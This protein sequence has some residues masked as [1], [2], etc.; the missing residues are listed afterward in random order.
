M[1]FWLSIA[2]APRVEPWDAPKPPD[3][4]EMAE[5]F[6]DP[7][8]N[9]D[10]EKMADLTEWLLGDGGIA[11]VGTVVVF[12]TVFPSIFSELEAGV[13]D[14]ESEER[15]GNF[16][17]DSYLD[18]DGW[19]R[20]TLPCGEA[21]IDQANMVVNT[22]FSK[23]GL[24]PRLWGA[25][26]NCKWSDAELNLDAEMGFF[27]PFAS[28]MIDQSVWEGEEGKWFYFDGELDILDYE[29][30]DAFQLMWDADDHMKILW[31]D[32]N[33]RFVIRAPV[34]EPETLELNI[35][36]LAELSSLTIEI[37]TGDGDWDCVVADGNCSGPSGQVIDW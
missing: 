15:A 6:S 27:V 18:G 17:E 30:N 9:L 7:K 23:E 31:E 4:F 5:K 1:L 36:D 25:S 2:C 29:V 16:E 34:I 33:S 8:G 24:D 32:G 22:L 10:E 11:V 3:M 19:L 21:D 26:E 14:E 35:E 37:A 13:S 20:L 12:Q 28:P